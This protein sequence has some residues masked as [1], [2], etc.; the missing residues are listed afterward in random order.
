VAQGK[1][2]EFKPQYCKK[3]KKK[4]KNKDKGSL[5]TITFQGSLV[6]VIFNDGKD[7]GK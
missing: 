7:Y 3:K 4:K 6:H 5:K 1:G 2:P